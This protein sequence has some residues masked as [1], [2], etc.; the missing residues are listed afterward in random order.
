MI[1]AIVAAALIAASDPSVATVA[2]KTITQSELEK[3]LAPQLTEIEQQRYEVLREGLDGMIAEILIEEE[4]KSRK[5]KPEDLVKQEIQDKVPAPTDTEIQKVYDEN[6]DAL[7]G[8]T[9][10]A[11]KERVV[12]YLQAQAMGA[13]Q[14]EFLGGL[15][16]KYKATIALKPP[17]IE[18]GVG[19]R[20][21]LGKKGAKVTIVMFSDYEC[22]FCKRAEPTVD[23]VMAAYGGQVALYFRDFPLPF[24][25]NA[26]PASEAAHCANAQGKFWDYHKKVMASEDLSRAK[27]NEI[28]ASTG[29]DGKK[30]EE[31]LDKGTYREAIDVDMSDGEA[32]GIDGT[33]AFFINGRR[34]SGAQ[35]FEKFKEII[36]EEL[37]GS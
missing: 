29:L 20:P 37:A 6:K 13:R 30:F 23:Q 19:S 27:L 17:K 16:K 32:A 34:L 28:A 4:A 10:E 31:C 36:D 14:E 33:P 18:V 7:G 22:P 9:L 21:P 26:R 15:R 12:E 11:V 35:P 25:Q 1:H 8:A 2:G 24:H 5:M 3:K